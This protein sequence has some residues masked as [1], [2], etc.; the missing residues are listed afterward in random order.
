M[1][2]RN[3]ALARRLWVRLVEGATWDRP[4]AA[5][6]DPAWHPDLEYVE[7]DRWPGSGHY[8]GLDAIRA[9]F[10]EYVEILGPIEITL[11]ELIDAGD[12]VVS[13]FH[14]RGESASTG[15]P[16]EHEWAYVWTV[17]DGRVVRWRAYF[18]KDEALEAVKP[19]AASPP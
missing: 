5:I 11:L 9:R 15:L 8:R 14:T 1:S 7:D 17:R 10:E 18:E 19:G 16:F 6:D 3:V 12:D 4:G 13:I 2:V